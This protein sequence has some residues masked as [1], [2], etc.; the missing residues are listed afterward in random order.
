MITRGVNKEVKNIG[1]EEEEDAL[2]KTLANLERL[3]PLSAW[4]CV[5]IL[6]Q[7]NAESDQY[8][9]NIA[10]IFELVAVIHTFTMLD[11]LFRGIIEH[12]RTHLPRYEH[13]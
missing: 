10:I 3:E 13:K 12:Y 8:G 9:D 6:E 2:Y 7:Y 5:N 11:V 4:A 1:T